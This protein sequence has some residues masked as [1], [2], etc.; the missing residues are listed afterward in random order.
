MNAVGRW[1]ARPGPGVLLAILLVI[2][3]PPLS[4]Q[5]PTVDEDR[6][7]DQRTDTRRGTFLGGGFAAAHGST[8]IGGE[9]GRKTGIGF[10][11]MIAGIKSNGLRS[12]SVDVQYEPFKVQ[13]PQRDERYSSFSIVA[14]GYLGPIGLGIGWQQRS[15]AGS[16]VWTS[17][18]G[19]IA[20]QLTAAAPL[21]SIGGLAVSP[22][23]FVRLSGGDEIATSSFGLRVP[24]GRLRG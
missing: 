2:A 14:S 3:S 12:F 15:W 4:A 19:G 11:G 10:L 22:D 1:A 8:K 17:S 13:N 6:S 23:L 9:T 21:I 7:G 24:F 20:L 5:E 18:D 16:D